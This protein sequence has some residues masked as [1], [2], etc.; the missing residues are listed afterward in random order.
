MQNND[1]KNK[2]TIANLF[3]NYDF[4]YLFANQQNKNQDFCI[5][6]NLDFYAVIFLASITDYSNLQQFDTDIAFWVL[7]YIYKERVDVGCHPVDT[8]V[9]FRVVHQHPK[10]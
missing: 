7:L 6:K 5:V 8:V 3:A 2:K 9:E 4:I 10:A 1:K